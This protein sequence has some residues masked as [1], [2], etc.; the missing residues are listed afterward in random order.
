MIACVLC[1]VCELSA[2]VGLGWGWVVVVCACVLGVC[3]SLVAGLMCRGVCVCV[4][5][6]GGGGGG[7]FLYTYLHRATLR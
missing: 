2:C 3:A 1:G 5:V 4:W 7:S 6:G